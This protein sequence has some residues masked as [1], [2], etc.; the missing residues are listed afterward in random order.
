M[1]EDQDREQVIEEGKKIGLNKFTVD[2]A[3][4]PEHEH[5]RWIREVRESMPGGTPIPDVLRQVGMDPDSVI[6]S[7]I[8]RA[9]ELVEMMDDFS[10]LQHQVTNLGSA[11]VE[12]VIVGLLLADKQGLA[13]EGDTQYRGR[14]GPNRAARRKK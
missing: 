8:K 1:S 4:E 10:T 12:G 6:K 13:P 3:E 11:W 5:Y 7:A 9:E 2:T 14:V